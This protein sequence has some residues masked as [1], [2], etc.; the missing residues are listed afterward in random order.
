MI[1]H[2]NHDQQL[3]VFIKA[4]VPGQCKTRLTPYLSSQQACDF[5]KTLIKN[6]MDNTPNLKATDIAIYTTP[7]IQHPYIKNLSQQYNTTLHS[8]QGK[9]LGERMHHALAESLQHY[10]KSILIGSDCPELDVKYIEKAFKALSQ[11]DKVTDIVLG[12]AEDG[13][14]VLLGARRI[15]AELFNNINWGTESVLQQTLK[16]VNTVGYHYHLLNTLRDIDTPED[17]IHYQSQTNPNEKNQ[18]ETP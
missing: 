1:K 4:P 14:Y 5:Y 2:K 8:Q 15:Q 13:G 3:I 18:Q 7:D 12:P 11:H 16:K 10:K 6:C 17:Y 9:D